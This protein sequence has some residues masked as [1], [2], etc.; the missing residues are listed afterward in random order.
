ML[1]LRQL[2]E[3]D[4][5]LDWYQ[6][7]NELRSQMVVFGNKVVSIPITTSPALLL[8]HMPTF[9]RDGLQVPVTWDQVLQLAAEY[10]GRDI[11]GDG[12]P[13]YSVC[14]PPPNCFADGALL[15]WMF[16]SFV[17]THGSSQGMFLDPGSLANLANS[18]AMVEALNLLRSLRV[19]AAQPPGDCTI[20]EDAL[21]LRGRC[22]MS[23][24]ALSTFK[25]AYVPNAPPAYAAMR[26]HMGMAMFPGSTRVL[27]RPTGR[28]VDCDASTC[29]LAR[30]TAPDRNGVVRPVNQP[31]PSSNV[32]VLINA[33]S[34]PEYQFYA[35]SLFS[36]LTSPHVMGTE[37]G[38]L[39]L[40]PDLETLPLRSSDLTPEAAARWVAYGYHPADVGQFFA[41]YTATLENPN[42]A[43]EP[44]FPGAL[45]VTQ[46]C[47]IAGVLYTNTTPGFQPP[48][49][50]VPASIVA[51]TVAG[52]VLE[53][54]GPEAFARAYRLT[55]N[56]APP[57]SPPPAGAT[58]AA[59]GGS[60]AAAAAQA[61]ASRHNNARLTS[62]VA[63]S[64]TVGLLA[65]VAVAATVIR[66]RRRRA[67]HKAV[68]APGVGPDTTLLVTDIQSSTSL[69]EHLDAGVMDHAL[70]VHHAVLRT[71]IAE[72]GGYESATEGDSF[73][74]AFP[75]P[76]AAL[77]CAL[78]AQQALLDAPWPTG[79]LHYPPL[80]GLEGD[81][82]PLLAVAAV[83]LQRWVPPLAVVELLPGGAEPGARDGARA[84]PVAS[85]A[86]NYGYATPPAPASCEE[87]VVSAAFPALAQLAADGD[88]GAAGAT[89]HETGTCPVLLDMYTDGVI[90]SFCDSHFGTAGEAGVSSALTLVPL[91][92]AQPPQ[93][94]S[95]KVPQHA[96]LQPLIRRAATTLS[97]ASRLRAS[98]RIIQGPAALEAT[99]QAAAPFTL[100]HRALS[101]TGAIPVTGPTV[102]TAASHLAQSRLAS[103]T[104]AASITTTGGGGAAA[105]TPPPVAPDA[106]VLFRG[107]RVRMGLWTG[108]G[109]DG[110]SGEVSVNAAT[111]RTQYS[112]DCMR[113]AKAVADT[114][115]GGMVVLTEASRSRLDP[116]AVR[117]AK[118]VVL[119]GGLHAV[120]LS[121]GGSG[122]TEELH[123]Y[124]AY[125]KPLLPRAVVV[126]AL[127]SQGVVRQGVLEAPVLGHGTV[128][129]MR[130][131][132]AETLLSWNAAVA[133]LALGRLHAAAMHMLHEPG[134]RATCPGAESS[135]AKLPVVRQRPHVVLGHVS[136][137]ARPPAPAQGG[138]GSVT[139]RSAAFLPAVGNMT[140][141]FPDGPEAA[142]MWALAVRRAALELE[143][144]PELLEHELAEEPGRRSVS[145][146]AVIGNG[147]ILTRPRT[148]AGPTVELPSAA[149]QAATDATADSTLELPPAAAGL[150]HLTATTV[151]FLAAPQPAAPAVARYQSGTAA[152]TPLPPSA[153]LPA[154]GSPVP[155]AMPPR[156]ASGHQ[157]GPGPG[158]T[159]AAAAG[160][161]APWAAH[162]SPAIPGS[163][164]RVSAS[165]AG[166]GGG[167]APA[168]NCDTGVHT[169][170]NS[171]T[172]SA[173]GG[174]GSGGWTGD[175]SPGL[176]GWAAS[177]GSPFQ[178][179]LLYRGLRLRWGVARGP[180]KGSLVAGDVS[181]Q[182]AYGGKAHAAAAKL[183]AKARAGQVSCR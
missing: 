91:E 25:A 150:D 127:R 6:I 180:L 133:T 117:A 26:G 76:T 169:H 124:T 142:V 63:V 92:C 107:L 3:S 182:L 12:T 165:G 30:A 20:Y 100:R 108:V 77:N 121:G 168:P 113:Y 56:W 43:F 27:D 58:A 14:L 49:A 24:T 35:Y 170:V 103:I 163:G 88:D 115:H 33:Q 175:K 57:P 37:A 15:R 148:A 86:S 29:P 38:G 164:L 155:A 93:D 176:P 147:A 71:A 130:I 122:G 83:P 40:D 41:A 2:V 183:A 79:L 126:P 139:S 66:R 85:A 101:I 119:Y 166:F 51:R 75:N 81:E 28:M 110:V 137:L 54:G 90:E 70:S 74:L 131:V 64:C 154:P 1:D 52:V 111:C 167:A 105:A 23:I 31:I 61:A 144:P 174:G 153:S 128:V 161:P 95:L 151:T 118:C 11:D 138:V 179:R 72:W 34:P 97:L 158:P 60:G 87:P 96:A 50:F 157:H 104:S 152:W 82:D 146:T 68:E 181:G 98:V 143:W 135:V 13:D 99:A 47:A 42:Q 145:G 16:S 134:S 109:A 89:L 48:P 172:A 44:R 69:W 62:I 39:V 123:L 84:G 160:E 125:G 9:E 140:V 112:G 136:L 36:F 32:I 55:L 120:K 73:I 67:W 46:A 5:Q 156:A 4:A 59:G 18:S 149:K 114:A 162:Q 22:L 94:R 78:A 178:Q 53:Q 80:P 102:G 141:V 7:S 171:T 10:K 129:Q 45:N 19:L 132:G 159:I 177:T 65:A 17:Q 116:A 173:T 106:V 8:Y 21:Y